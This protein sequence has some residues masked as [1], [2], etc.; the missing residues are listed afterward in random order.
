MNMTM[1]TALSNAV[2]GLVNVNAQLAVLSQNIANASTPSYAVE[3][4]TQQAQTAGG[5]GFGVRTG[6]A[7]RTIDRALQAAVTDQN[8]DVAGLATTQAALLAIDPVLGTPGQGSDLGSLLGNLKN[9]FTTLLTDPSSQPQQSAVVASAATLAQGINTIGNAYAAQRQAAQDNLGAEVAVLNAT[10][11]DIGT[12]S[13]QI[14][15]AKANNQSTAD[16]ENQRDAAVQTLSGL[17]SVK[18]QEQPDGGL[19]VFTGSG[20]LL[21]TVPGTSPF[22]FSGGSTPPGSYYPGG[23]LSG[24][25]LNGKDVTAQAAGGRIGANIALRDTT[26]PGYQA[27]LDEFAQG[28]SSRFA[29]Q[30]LTLFSD[31]RGNVPPG[32]GTP[33]QANYVGYAAIIQVNPAVS[34]NPALVRDGTAAV[35][36]SATGASAF[37]PNPSG[38]PAGFSGLVSRVLDYTFTGLAQDGVAQPPLNTTGLGAT[39]NLS[40]PFDGAASLSDFATSLVAAQAQASA[41]ATGDLTTATALQTS[42]NAKV[43]NESGVS[44]DS[45]MSQM[46]VLQNAY[47]ANARVM[48]ALQ[49]MFT[50]LL[51]AVQ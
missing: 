30:G 43:S 38:G 5:V 3:T 40:A 29:A 49:S 20:L 37:T 28:L 24:I 12:I 10:L 42:L 8:A 21:P 50:Q 6:P 33:A 48:N 27:E 47:G 14:V 35:A 1:T 4:S 45:E 46:L 39:G 51:Q 25:T 16:L 32:G 9:S 36:G 41:A 15:A 19:S 18:T 11:G 31:A 34:A 44:I 26:L 2:S 17:I 22:G 7:T 13:D 23:G